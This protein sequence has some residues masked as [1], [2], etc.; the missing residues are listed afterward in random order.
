MPINDRNPLNYDELRLMSSHEDAD[1]KDRVVV[2]A[3]NNDPT[4]GEVYVGVREMVPSPENAGERIAVLTLAQC[5][6]LMGYLGSLIYEME[7][8]DAKS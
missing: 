6:L 4:S 5:R 1:E 2:G 3:R 8:Q 7:R